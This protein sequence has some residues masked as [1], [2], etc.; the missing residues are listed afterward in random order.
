PSK[1]KALALERAILNCADALLESGESGTPLKIYSYALKAYSPTNRAAALKGFARADPKKAIPLIANSLDHSDRPMRQMAVRLAQEIPGK[2]ATKMLAGRLISLRPKARVSLL[3][4]LAVRKDNAALPAVMRCCSAADGSVRIAALE[5]VGVLGDASAVESLALHAARA[6][7]DEREAARSAMQSLRGADVNPAMAKLLKSASDSARVELIGAL[8][9]RNAS[10]AK[11]AIFK[12]AAGGNAQVRIASQKALRTLAGPEDID[13]LLDLLESAAEEDIDEAAKTVAIISE[14]FSVAP[15]TT[16]IG[17]KRLSKTGDNNLR[18]AMLILLGGLGDTR[19]LPALRSALSDSDSR[20]R[21]AAVRGL[22]Q[23][24]DAAPNGEPMD[25]LLRIAQTSQNKVHRVLALRGYVNL[26]TTAENLS[27]TRKARACKTAI[28]LADGVAEKTRVLAKTAELNSIEALE[29]AGAYLDDR[30]L[31]NEAAVA[32]VA[33]AQKAFSQ[34]LPRAKAILKKVLESDVAQG[35]KQKAS[36]IL[37][38]ID[39]I[40]GYLVD[41]EVTGPYVKKDKSFAELFDIPFGPEISGADATW[42]PMPVTK[43]GAHPAYLDLLKELNGG[44]LRVAYLRTTIQSD[45]DAAVTF[46]MYTDDGVKAWLN[47]KLIHALNVPRA[48]PA[49]PDVVNATLRKGPNELMLKI[50]QNNMP[51]GAIVLLKRPAP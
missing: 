34:D 47:G 21:D 42:R 5:A 2:D 8:A 9:G 22:S 19:A 23:W 40:K 37:L 16:T 46:E 49:N 17:L 7:G 18:V 12:T 15:M 43:L 25:D 32:A 11:P 44:D 10:E 36:A 39:S 45:S 20:V 13:V 6:R 24:P 1:I 30:S 14:R 35:V 31:K 29:V 33:I 48:I 51:W 50:T 28:E 4:A 27:P 26:I 41:W 38:D 3:H